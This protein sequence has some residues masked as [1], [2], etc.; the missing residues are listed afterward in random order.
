MAEYKNRTNSRLHAQDASQDP[1]PPA[2][3]AYLRRRR[4]RN[5]N[6]SKPEFQIF[7]DG[8]VEEALESIK[9]YPEAQEQNFTVP[10]RAFPSTSS[11]VGKKSGKA[12]LREE[13]TNPDLL[14]PVWGSS[15]ISSSHLRYHGS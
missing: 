10:T 14:F 11:M 1:Q 12:L 15:S 5:K 6:I 3:T 7:I 4:P 9:D 13:G 2:R 8:A